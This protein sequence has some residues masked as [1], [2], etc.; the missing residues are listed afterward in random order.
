MNLN[1]RSQKGLSQLMSESDSKKHSHG[2]HP[3]GPSNPNR[4]SSSSSSSSAARSQ[5]RAAELV[6]DGGQIPD[7]SNV[8]VN[9]HRDQV[10]Y[11]KSMPN[12]LEKMKQQALARR[13]LTAEQDLAT[14]Q[15]D[16]KV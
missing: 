16:S 10:E 13:G 9:K 6:F 14:R 7:E 5:Q 4:P 15:R 12:F 1:D 3:K 2:H 8:K 11:T